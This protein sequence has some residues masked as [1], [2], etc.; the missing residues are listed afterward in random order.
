MIG[1]LEK[2]RDLVQ[3]GESLIPRATRISAHKTDNETKL[4][5]RL[6]IA[7]EKKSTWDDEYY[8]PIVNLVRPSMN[9]PKGL[10]VKFSNEVD[11][12]D[13]CAPSH[14]PRDRR[15]LAYI[16]PCSA[17][18]RRLSMVP[19]SVPSNASRQSMFGVVQKASKQISQLKINVESAD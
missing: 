17:T 16:V 18:A 2:I 3:K 7:V 6:Q 19:V 5:Q 9:E 12:K 14:F 10:G 8:L 13:D 4:V 11:E 1:L 15:P